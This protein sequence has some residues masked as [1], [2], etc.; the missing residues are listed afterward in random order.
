MALVGFWD[1]LGSRALGLILGPW[2]SSVPFASGIQF[3][4]SSEIGVFAKLTNKYCLTA[5]GGS[6]NFYRYILCVHRFSWISRVICVCVI[7]CWHSLIMVSR[8]VL[9]FSSIFYDPCLIS[10]TFESEL[11]D[12]MP[13]V[14]ASIA[15]TR[16]IG[17]MCV[18]R[19][20]FYQLKLSSLLMSCLGSQSW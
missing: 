11:S 15:G 7:L 6:E 8:Q 20:S 18:G 2:S 17:R 14:K 10:S 4:N 19:I 1:L 12:H 3:E 5:I 9:W 16:I 13:V